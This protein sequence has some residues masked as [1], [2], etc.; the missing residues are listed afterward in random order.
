[1]DFHRFFSLLD[2]MM[3]TGIEI[4]STIQSVERQV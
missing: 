2:K 4:N 3:E 1:M